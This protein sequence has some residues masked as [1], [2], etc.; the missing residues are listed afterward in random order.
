[1]ISLARISVPMCFE[2]YVLQTNKRNMQEQLAD[3]EPLA[4]VLPKVLPD[5]LT[6]RKVETT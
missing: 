6:A 3:G 5:V 2:T 1:M 4:V